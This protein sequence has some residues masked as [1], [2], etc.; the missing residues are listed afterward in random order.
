MLSTA[1]AVFLS[2]SSQQRV[3][4]FPLGIT[5]SSHTKH[6]Y[7][8]C[9]HLK[10]AASRLVQASSCSRK[11]SFCWTACCCSRATMRNSCKTAARHLSLYCSNSHGGCV[12]WGGV[13]NRGK[14]FTISLDHVVFVLLHGC[15]L[16]SLHYALTE[17]PSSAAW[18]TKH[19]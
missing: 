17:R 14:S 6:V 18:C 5:P 13:C 11:F 12:P 10:A 19:Q 9:M 15:S 7:S 16:L 1:R 2:A 8:S 3:S 4:D